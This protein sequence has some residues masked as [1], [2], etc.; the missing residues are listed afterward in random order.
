MFFA[1]MSLL[2]LTTGI[3]MSWDVRSLF[4][5]YNIVDIGALFASHSTRME[6]YAHHVV[7][8]YIFS[9]FFNNSTTFHAMNLAL[10][11]ELIS[12]AN[13]WENVAG[14]NIFRACTIVVV[15]LPIWVRLLHLMIT[16]PFLPQYAI[17]LW[18]FFPCIDFYFLTKAI[19]RIRKVWK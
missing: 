1:G 7:V 9:V 4:I 10:L 19:G 11:S 5:A 17:L 14:L 18:G 16:A 6:L 2:Y 13:S 12:V 8:L 15:R 3:D